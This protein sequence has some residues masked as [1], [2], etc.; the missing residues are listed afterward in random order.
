MLV[1]SFYVITVIGICASIYFC[2]R[3]LRKDFRSEH[4]RTLECLK[5]IRRNFQV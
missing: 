1:N 2:N 3:S 4:L 5:D